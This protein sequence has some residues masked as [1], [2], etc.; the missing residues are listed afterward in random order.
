ML[1][2]EFN[3]NNFSLVYRLVFIRDRNIYKPYYNNYILIIIL[4]FL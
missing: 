1:D 4:W 2:F 3:N